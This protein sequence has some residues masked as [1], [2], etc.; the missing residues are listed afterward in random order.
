MAIDYEQICREN[1]EEYGK[2][3]RHLEFFERLYSD[4]THFIFE[5]LQNAEDAHAT[6]IEFVLFDARLEVR[7]DGRPFNEKDVRGVCGVGESTKGDDYTQIGRFG[8]GFKSVYAFT[9]SPVIH[10]GDEHFQIKNYVRPYVVDRAVIEEPWT[11]LIIIPF[12]KTDVSSDFAVKEIANRL[13]CLSARTLLFLARVS[14]IEYC[15]LNGECGAY[16]KSS[17]QCFESTLVTVIGEK[18]GTLEVESEEW[19]VFQQSILDGSNVP[20]VGPN[21]AL[22][23]PVQIAFLLEEEEAEKSKLISRRKKGTTQDHLV[24]KRI[25]TLTKSPLVVF[26][27]TEKDSQLGFLTQGPYRTTPARDN[28]PSHDEWNQKLINKTAGLLVES[29]MPGLKEMDLLTVSCFDAFPID[30]DDFPEDGFFFPIAEEFRSALQSGELL[31][32]ADGSFVSGERAVL[33]RGEDLRNLLGID[34]LQILFDFPDGMKWLSGEITPDNAPKLRNYLRN[35]LSVQEITPDAFAAKIT[36]EFMAQQSDDWVIAFYGCL[37][38]WE[39]LW[40]PRRDSWSRA[41]LKDRPFLR[42]E[43][44]SHVTPFDTNG[45]P[46]AYLPL[47]GTTQLPIVRECVAADKSARDFLT[48][49]G[50]S[51]PDLVAVLISEILPLYSNAESTPTAADHDDHVKEILVAWSTDSIAKKKQ[52]EEKLTKTP[53]IRYHCRATGIHR[54]AQPG[55]VYFADDNLLMY[56]EGN[57]DVKF[58]VTSYSKAVRELLFELGVAYVPRCFEVE[59]GE[60]PHIR[61]TTRKHKIKNYVLDGLEDFLARLV[62]E[63]N[64]S[65]RIDMALLLWNYLLDYAESDGNCFQA[66]RYYFYYSPLQQVYDALFVPILRD[67][68]WIPTE[69]GFVKPPDVSISQLPEMFRRNQKLIM[70]L[71]FKPDPSQQL[72]Q[73]RQAKHSL[74]IQLGISLEDAEFIHQNRDEF[75]QFRQAMLQRTSHQRIIED[76]PSRNRERRRAK[77][78]ERRDLAPTKESVMK[79]RAVPNYSRLEIDREALFAFYY[80]EDVGVVFC[81]MCLDPMPFVKRNGEEAGECVDLFTKGWANANNIELKVITPLNLV[82]CPVCSEVYQDYV[83]KDLGRQTK[84]YQQVTSGDVENLVV[85]E[86][87]V[88][89]DHKACV[90]HFN[91]THLADIRDCLDS[92]YYQDAQDK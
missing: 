88:R 85:C 22:V 64:L 16:M 78:L 70:A 45:N 7:H 83:H 86:K 31:P 25:S 87:D 38:S 39:S 41:T 48:R 53:F 52:L 5:L 84:L 24:G 80:D 12:D 76:E 63:S 32:A 90:L 91:P 40:K 54:Y 43:S 9:K 6:R 89:R 28:I 14:E 68:E 82:L 69:D 23:P 66:T 56:F 21:E 18:G 42:L 35:E 74:A 10:C 11:T 20:I 13:R 60:P 2:G 30:M 58:V 65:V 49:L 67:T 44:G 34:Q 77:L 33:G 27:P 47:K 37:L 1:I 26:F 8:I 55:D 81:Q 46:N 72:E 3:T 92:V 51:E 29:V 15:I 79:L 62:N 19:L 4:G 71:N 75:D 36:A 59:Y 57:T 61:Y 17:K 73:E 50:I